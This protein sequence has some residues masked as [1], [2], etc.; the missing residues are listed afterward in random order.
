[1]SKRRVVVTGVGAASP[2]GLTSSDLWSGLLEG[3]SGS[4]TIRVFDPAAFPCRLA[5]EVPAYNIRDYVPK[6]YRKAT[7][8]MSRDIELSVIAADEAVKNSGLVTKASEAATVTVAPERFAISFGAGLIS[9]D[10]DEIAPCVAMSVTDGKFDIRK[11]GKD[12]LQ[13]LTPLWLLKYLPNMLPCHVGIIHD[14]Q[15]PSN[16]ITC[17]ETAGHIAVAEAAEMVARGDADAALAGGCEAKVNPI[18]MLRQ[19]LLKRS[20][21]NANDRPEQACRP[22]DAAAA[23]SVFGEAGGV[24]VLEELKF[25]QSR[26]AVIAAELAGTASS[27]TLNP[28]FTHLEADGKGLQIAIHKAL[29]DANVRPDQIDLIIPTGTGIPADDKAEAAALEAV[30]GPALSSIHAWPIKSMVTHTGAA[31]GAIDL[32]AAVL[33]IRHGVIGPAKNF[34]RPADGCRLKIAAQM[35]KKDIRFALCCG[36]SFGGQTAAVVLKKYE[37]SA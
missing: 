29:Q 1:M 37:E 14:I 20:A 6:S 4:Q 32:I 22:F 2:L 36:Y 35:T 24:L 12:G 21:Q 7:K 18:V 3:R 30:F 17:G 9:C 34:D 25:A 13:A 33:A 31:A 28:E 10:L 8:L 11:W 23:G 26:K 5:G 27:N 19:C 16:T 15:G